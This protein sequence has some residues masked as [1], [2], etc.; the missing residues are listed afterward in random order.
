MRPGTQMTHKMDSKISMATLVLFL[1][2]TLKV[3]WAQTNVSVTQTT[4]V[5]NITAS[6]TTLPTEGS[7]VTREANSTQE[8][9]LAEQTTNQQTLTSNS[10][11][12]ATLGTSPKATSTPSP[13]TTTRGV[14]RPTYDP[15]WDNDFKYDYESLRC[16]GLIIAAVLFVM[17]ILTIS[18]GKMCRLPKCR[19]RSSKSY[20]VVQG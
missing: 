2:I 13:T 5:H 20:R 11:K 7:G 8:A 18:C 1:L 3:S 14:P 15:K 12:N 17:G 6:P 4:P 19:K 16:A 10:V 9:T